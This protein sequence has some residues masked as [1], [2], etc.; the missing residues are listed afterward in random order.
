[1]AL[2][3]EPPGPEQVTTMS[4]VPVLVYGPTFLV[5][6]MPPWLHAVALLLLHVSLA[7]VFSGTEVGD[8]VAV[9]VGALAAD[10]LATVTVTE[11]EVLPFA[12]RHVRVCVLVAVGV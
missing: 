3:V 10:V 1:T 4:L 9:T 12:L 5:P 8:T 11:R 2:D 7:V 6:L